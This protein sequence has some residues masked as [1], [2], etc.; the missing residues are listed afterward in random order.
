MQI[1]VDKIDIEVE[2]IGGVGQKDFVLNGMANLISF[3]PPLVPSDPVPT[4]TAQ[5]NY[6][7]EDS[8]GYNLIGAQNLVGKTAVQ[9]EI[10]CSKTNTIKLSN[11]FDGTHKI[12]IYYRTGY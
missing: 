7:I 6:D 12:R 3:K 9:V 2:V 8:D 5:Y 11:A 1:K 4:D 10:L